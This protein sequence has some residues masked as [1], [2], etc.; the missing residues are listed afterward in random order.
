[1]SVTTDRRNCCSPGETITALRG[2]KNCGHS[3]EQMATSIEKLRIA[4]L[5]RGV[6]GIH[7]MGRYTEPV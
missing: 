2:K 6:N 3:V 7:G 4:C 5:Q 1:M